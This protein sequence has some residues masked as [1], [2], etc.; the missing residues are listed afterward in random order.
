ML[1]TATS[2]IGATGANIIEVHHYRAFS[3]LS[4]KLADLDV[5]PE[6][7]GRDHIAR[8]ADSLMEA[9]FRVRPVEFV[10]ASRQV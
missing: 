9:G 7:L 4:V 8:T 6:T 3:N 10:P 5:V 1:A 2:I